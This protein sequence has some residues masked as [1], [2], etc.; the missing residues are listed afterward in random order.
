ML[1]NYKRNIIA[2]LYL[3]NT[4]LLCLMLSGCEPSMDT[5]EKLDNQFK[6]AQI[7]KKASDKNVRYA[8]LE[9]LT[10]QN[11][12]ATISIE[13]NNED[14]CNK[15]VIKIHESKSLLKVVNKAR[16]N[17]VRVLAVGNVNDEESLKLIA[18]ENEDFLLR[19]IATQ[20]ISTPELIEEIAVEDPSWIVRKVATEKVSNENI[21]KQILSKDE[22]RDIWEVALKKIYTQS[23]LADAYANSTGVEKRISI[24]KKIDDQNLLVELYWQ[25]KTDRETNIIYKKITDPNLKRKLNQEIERLEKEKK[26]Q[27]IVTLFKNSRDINKLKS[28]IEKINDPNFLAELYFSHVS[29]SAVWQKHEISTALVEQL[30]NLTENTIDINDVRIGS[31]IVRLGP[32]F[33]SIPTHRKESFVSSFIHYLKAIYSPEILEETGPITSIMI[34]WEELYNFYNMGNLKCYGDKITFQ[35]SFKKID[36]VIT[37]N[38]QTKFQKY[39][40]LLKDNECYFHSYRFTDILENVVNHLSNDLILKIASDTKFSGRLREAAI[41]KVDDDKLLLEVYNNSKNE[42]LKIAVI[43]N[44][45]NQQF[46]DDIA[47]SS[48]NMLLVKPAL[49][50]ISN[51][52]LLTEIALNHTQ[53][54]ARF[55]AVNSVT[56]IDLLRKIKNNST[57]KKIKDQAEYRIEYHTKNP[58]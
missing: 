11:I 52:S 18:Q 5:V 4:F 50:R 12:L 56:T 45:N 1:I 41:D 8:A 24:V 32:S 22:P 49:S 28:E 47:T 54:E 29:T 7:L 15:A 44:I 20:K 17:S 38:W 31:T 10:D 43:R 35:L 55:A 33:S 36:E 16:F 39:V 57:D 37:L 42:G 27:Q 48:K 25:K 51:E 34:Q 13:N 30:L 40:T 19:K 3:S 46:I 9:K 14:I 6:L 2:I 21:L 58:K 53:P 26:E 23:D